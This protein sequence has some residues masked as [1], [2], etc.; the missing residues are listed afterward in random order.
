MIGA[1]IN[2]SLFWFSFFP[3]GPLRIQSR[4]HRHFGS[5]AP[6]VHTGHPPHFLSISVS[7]P[8]MDR[9]ICLPDFR[10]KSLTRRIIFMN[11]ALMGIIRMDMAMFCI[12]FTI[13]PNCETV[14][15]QGGIF[16]GLLAQ[17]GLGKSQVLRHNP[18]DRP[19]SGC[20]LSPGNRAVV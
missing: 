8:A 13:C 7:S 1:Q 17:H 9:L 3:C 11:V 20:L 14:L 2:I 6:W 19:V 16:H 18:Q 5:Y 10:D 12:L 15:A 4:D